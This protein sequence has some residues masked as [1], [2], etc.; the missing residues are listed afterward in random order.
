MEPFTNFFQEAI[1]LNLAKEKQMTRTKSNAY[2]IPEINE[3]FGNK[4]RLVY[5]FNFDFEAAFSNVVSDMTSSYNQIS[6][7]IEQHGYDIP[8]VKAYIDGICKKPGDK[9]IYK[10]GRI[11]EKLKQPMVSIMGR[12]EESKDRP[13]Y[14]HLF[15]TDPIRHVQDNKTSIVISRHP[16]DIYGMSTGRSWTSCVDLKYRKEGNNSCTLPAEVN[17][18]TLVA[19]LIPSSE[20]RPNGKVDLRKPVSRITL[21]PLRNMEGELGY[22]VAKPYG[23]AMMEFTNFCKKWAVKNFNSKVK[24]RSGFKLAN[25]VYPDP[26]NAEGLQKVTDVEDKIRE[27]VYAMVN[28]K[29]EALQAVSRANRNNVHIYYSYDVDKED[30]TFQLY[31]GVYWLIT[32]SS[33]KHAIKSPVR[34]FNPKNNPQMWKDPEF[35]K[36]AKQHGFYDHLVWN[37]EFFQ[38]VSINARLGIIK[39]VF[40]TPDGNLGTAQDLGDILLSFLQG[41]CSILSRPR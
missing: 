21:K 13:K 10:I 4:D 5:D 38:G 9:N 12:N 25:N 1:D 26:H 31:G 3:V 30:N 17:E 32:D 27:E 36:I 40:S 20:V 24:N 28:L 39:I 19:Y 22:G 8:N 29:N 34:S 18:G 33:I 2:K 14:T 7:F 6:N 23:A 35:A 16:Y 15:K 11:L 37:N 41:P